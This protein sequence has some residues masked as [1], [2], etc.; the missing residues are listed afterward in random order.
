M[1][2]L[3]YFLLYLFVFILGICIGSFMNV[4]MYRLPNKIS[5]RG[6]SFCTECHTQIKTYDLIPLL[7]YII[8]KGRCR[9]CKCRISIKYFLTELFFGLIAVYIFI[10]YY[11]NAKALL[12]FAFCAVLIT[13]SYIEYKYCYI[14]FCLIVSM[15]ICSI[16]SIFIFKDISL[17]SR[18]IGVAIF[19]VPSVVINLIRKNTIGRYD[20]IVI[21]ATGF[22]LG[23]FLHTLAIFISLFMSGIY[24]LIL[25]PRNKIS[26]G[27]R[28][29]VIPFISLCSM[30]SLMYGKDIL[31]FCINT[32]SSL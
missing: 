17:I 16:I 7:S 22:F 21:A 14:P 13:V 31:T 28:V 2:Y 27:D 4:L 6:R 18:I 23:A 24:I 25:K 12:A 19:S 9:N 20:I 30:I 26:D 10:H 5:L 32:V 1:L 15:I 8:L 11:F 3:M 29:S